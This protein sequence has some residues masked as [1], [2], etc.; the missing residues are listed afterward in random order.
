MSPGCNHAYPGA[1]TELPSCAVCLERLDPSVS[2]VY[3]LLCT[4]SFHSGCLRRWQDSSCPVCRHVQA[5]TTRHTP[6]DTRHTTHDTRHTTHDTRHTT[7]LRL[8]C[9]RLWPWHMRHE[10]HMWAAAPAARGYSACARHGGG[11]HI[12]IMP[13]IHCR[14]HASHNTHVIRYTSQACMHAGMHAHAHAH[15]M[16]RVQEE[17]TEG[18]TA[19]E[20]CGTQEKVW[21]WPR[22]GLQPHPHTAACNPVYPA[23]SR[24]CSSLQPQACSLQP[25]A[26]S[27]QP[28]VP[29]CG[30]A[31]CAAT[32]AA[33]DMAA[34]QGCATTNRRATTSQW[35]LRRSG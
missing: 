27:L 6:H 34:V 19:C 33:V 8:R 16:C 5:A 10:G 31:S 14:V 7:H 30:S 9:T 15:A 12:H 32:W 3:T 21:P 20:R 29:R 24:M 26:C 13:H 18:G 28:R 1:S 22:L 25:A 2:G 23:C 17:S 4:H 11:Y 35:S